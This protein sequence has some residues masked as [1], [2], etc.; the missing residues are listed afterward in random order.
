[1]TSGLSEYELQRLENI[2]QN[3]RI[4]QQ[5]NLADFVATERTSAAKRRNAPP[6]RPLVKR[7]KTD[8]V[9]TRT[10]ARLAKRPAEDG[11]AHQI[12]TT[13]EGQ[14]PAQY[15]VEV[16]APFEPQNDVDAAH[17]SS[18]FG[19]I[20]DHAADATAGRSAGRPSCAS[21]LARL[22]LS[23]SDVRKTVPERIYRVA[24]HPTTHAP[25]LLVGDKR[26]NLGVWNADSDGD[27][28]VLR[29]HGLPVSGIVVDPSNPCRVFTCGYDGTVVASDLRA[30]TYLAVHVDADHADFKGMAL[31]SADGSV[32]HIAMEGGVMRTL[33]VRMGAIVRTLTPPPSVESDRIVRQ[34]TATTEPVRRSTRARKT[35]ASLPDRAPGVAPVAPLP[36]VKTP[37]HVARSSS[38][39]EWPLHE[40]KMSS[41]DVC[42]TN[43]H[44][45]ATASLDRTV[46]LWDARAVRPK[47]LFSLD[48]GKSV[49]SAYF[50]RV[51]GNR[52]LTTSYDDFL[53]VV[54]DVPHVTSA[55]AAVV[56][57]IRHNNQTGRWVTSFRAEWDPL[58]DGHFAVGSMERAIDYFEAPQGVGKGT[59]VSSL[60]SDELMTAI[61]AVVAFHP[62][63]PW[64]AGGTGS[65]RVCLF[66]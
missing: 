52:L 20:A 12:D 49:T 25:V 48:H 39:G 55:S 18:Y 53:R 22:S 5:L 50:S 21:M 45:I 2:R 30:C 58:D 11:P 13:T 28:I 65:G 38:R 27:H 1:M 35:T 51:T 8:S 6:T 37:A 24:F 10:S 54:E 42:P 32:L 41:V 63:L 4:L 19:D 46:A 34:P 9:P 26:G 7:P 15:R 17:V 43:S 62:S 57:R 59:L 47:P 29:P 23:E 14:T 64:I 56:T 60:R 36:A 33:D 16:D 31:G 44:L 40:R 66:R 61:P 3:Q